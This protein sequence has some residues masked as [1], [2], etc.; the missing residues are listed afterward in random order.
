VEPG[1]GLVLKEV[2]PV[3]LRSSPDPLL[4]EFVLLVVGFFMVVLPSVVLP[5]KK[6]LLLGGVGSLFGPLVDLDPLPKA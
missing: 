1:P 4:N 6:G 2:N 5:A 3:R